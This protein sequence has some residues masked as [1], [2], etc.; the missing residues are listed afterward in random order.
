MILCQTKV[1]IYVVYVQLFVL[2]LSS[3]NS[4]G[5]Y[6]DFVP[7]KGGHLCSICSVVCADT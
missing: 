1:G 4:C 5:N 3:V 2:K 7:N 6:G